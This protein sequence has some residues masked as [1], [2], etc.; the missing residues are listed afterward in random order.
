MTLS[1]P[2]LAAVD[3]SAAWAWLA[4]QL[5]AAT[6]SARHGFHL[7]TVATVGTDGQPDARTVVLRHVDPARRLIR[8]HSDIRSPKVRAIQRDPRV[9]LHW[10]DPVIRV[11][12]RIDARATVHHGDE[13]A[14]AAW[15]AAAPMSRACYTAFVAPGDPLDAFPAGPAAP[16]TGDD[17]GLA[18]FT[19]VSC[20]FDSVD[21]LVL[22]AAGHQRVRLHLDREP[23]AWTVLSP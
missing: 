9:A 14:A 21:L 3:A 5:T 17:A 12:V 1:T 8:F 15:S 22:H 23:T 19:I 18:H 7:M 11:Q 20:R 6:G 16:A 13:I 4:G 2:D 10:Y